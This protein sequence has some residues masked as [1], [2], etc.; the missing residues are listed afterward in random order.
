MK[1]TYTGKSITGAL[2]LD[3]SIANGALIAQMPTTANVANVLG[4]AMPGM[5]AHGDRQSARAAFA[6]L[7]AFM[8]MGIEDAARAVLDCAGAVQL[9]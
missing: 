3:Q 1:A 8:G 9:K 6:A 7:A 4:Y 5:H 2:K